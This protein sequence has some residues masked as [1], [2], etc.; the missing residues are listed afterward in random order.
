MVPAL[1]PIDT[2]RSQPT[3]ETV[4]DE[5]YRRIVEGTLPPGSRISEAD[6]ASRLG[7]SRQPV[8][9]AFSRLHK[10]NLVSITPN[11]AT[12][13]ALVSE[14]A[15]LQARFVRKALETEIARI[16]AQGIAEHWLDELARLVERQVVAIAADDRLGFHELDDA[17]HATICDAVGY[18]F[19]W[20]LIRES[21]AQ[22]DRVR[23]LSLAFGAPTALDDH[24]RIVAAI[25]ARDPEAAVA[26]VRAHLDRILRILAQVR[27]NHPE[28]F[29]RERE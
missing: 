3:A 1:R 27:G 14:T 17:F 20:T 26:A 13:V 2:P 24:R 5:L 25:R 19:A 8:R 16:A 4:Y 6:T 15:V 12:V 23:W 7:V 28:L 9:E 11:R 29:A 21:K 10:L 22:M 18:G